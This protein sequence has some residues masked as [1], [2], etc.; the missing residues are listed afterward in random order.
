[1][2]EESKHT[3]EKLRA[4]LDEMNL[5]HRKLNIEYK[6]ITQKF[7]FI[8]SRKN[9]LTNEIHKVEDSIESETIFDTVKY[10]EELNSLSPDERIIISTGMDKTDYRKYQSNAPRWIDLEKIIKQVH[11]F[12]NTYPGWI[13]HNV[14][15]TGQLDVMPPKSI[16]K[17]TYLTPE[18]YFLSHG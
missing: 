16:Y 4:E 3:L 13:L 7:R 10:M 1:M 11:E 12:K 18:G 2:L 15:K 6:N 14:V 8:E 5:E 17:F 9:T